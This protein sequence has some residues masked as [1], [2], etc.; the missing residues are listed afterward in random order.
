MRGEGPCAVVALLQVGQICCL[1]R[2]SA[3]VAAPGEHVKGAG[4]EACGL[5]HVAEEWMAC[6]SALPVC[7]SPLKNCLGISHAR[8]HL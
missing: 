8:K 5:E 7:G 1:K 6:C 4:W 2:S 3:R